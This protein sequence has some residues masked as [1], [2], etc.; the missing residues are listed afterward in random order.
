MTRVDPMVIIDEA[1]RTLAIK[2]GRS[3]VDAPEIDREGFREVVRVVLAAAR[4]YDVLADG[5]LCEELAR[6]P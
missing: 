2:A 5:P 1:A 3:W 6:F 4:R